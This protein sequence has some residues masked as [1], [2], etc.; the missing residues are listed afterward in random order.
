LIEGYRA[1]G[2]Q[3]R[4]DDLEARKVALEQELAADPPP[5]VRLHPNLAQVYPAKVE[6]L[7]EAFT[8]PGLRDEALGILRGLIE[9]VVVH[10]GEDGPQIELVGEIVRMVELGLNAKQAA[11]PGEAACSVKVV[12][13]ARN[14]Y[15][16]LLFA[17]RLLGSNCAGREGSNP[18]SLRQL[19]TIVTVSPAD[20]SLRSV[21]TFRLVGSARCIDFVAFFAPKMRF[22]RRNL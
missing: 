15:Y 2:L 21:G 5:P 6:R 3:Q 9:R 11:L 7:H 17:T 20:L 13:G 10:P 14:T 1:D 4:L 8:D 16:L 22:R 12:A 19:L 18:V